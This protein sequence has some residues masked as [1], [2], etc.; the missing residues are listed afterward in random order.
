MGDE[1]GRTKGGA[2]AAHVPRGHAMSMADWKLQQQFELIKT[3]A[4]AYR[5]MLGRKFD[6]YGHTV[7]Q[8]CE[9]FLSAILT[10]KTQH[11]SSNMLGDVVVDILFAELQKVILN[12]LLPGLSLI[13]K[14]AS[15]V[16]PITKEFPANYHD[17]DIRSLSN[18]DWLAKATQYSVTAV[19]KG[20]K[21]KPGED[22]GEVIKGLIKEI[23]HEARHLIS[24]AQ[25][26]IDAIPVNVA[27]SQFKIVDATINSPAVHDEGAFD[28]PE[29]GQVKRG[30]TNVILEGMGAPKTGAIE[31]GALAQGMLNA[32]KRHRID[33]SPNQVEA[34]E[35]RQEMLSGSANREIHQA[36]K[37]VD[38]DEEMRADKRE[39]S[40]AQNLPG[41]WK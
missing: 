7:D 12:D 29:D 5:E 28:S 31:A 11:K 18:I 27:A 26:Q 33:H 37:D 22:D 4:T 30:A 17:I 8:A 40:R 24:V 21:A 39:R 23:K 25:T 35:K 1:G 41:A 38:M 14:M 19:K 2:G 3:E 34:G 15:A 20:Y 9:L 10:E 16:G 6:N 32:Y 36:A 13:Q